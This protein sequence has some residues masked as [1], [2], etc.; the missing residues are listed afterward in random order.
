M[1]NLF[2]TKPTIELLNVQRDKRNTADTNYLVFTPISKE[3]HDNFVDALRH[4][5]MFPKAAP[6]RIELD[7]TLLK[8]HKISFENIIAIGTTDMDTRAANGYIESNTLNINGVV[9][10]NYKCFVNKDWK[11]PQ[12]KMNLPYHD[13]G[14]CS[15]NCLMQKLK[16]PKYGVIYLI[17]S[18]QSYKFEINGL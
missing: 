5:Q 10:R 17:P 18:N 14:G 7:A 2:P 11:D 16:H 15:W 4:Y 8:A 3:E 13:D 12:N 1:K 6:K 9:R